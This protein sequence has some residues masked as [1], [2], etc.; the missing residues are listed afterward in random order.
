[1][2]I[3]HTADWHLGR[4]LYHKTRYE[5]FRQFLDWLLEAVQQH[6]IDVLI[7]AGDVFDTTAPSNRA[8]ELYYGFLSLLSKTC[9]RHVV[10]IAG[11]HDS[12]T[13]LE[14]PRKLLKSFD[15][16][17][18]GNVPDPIEEEVILLRDRNGDPE[19]I[20]CAVPY[21]RDRDVRKSE[22]GESL[23]AKEK[24]LREGIESHY[25]KVA[26]AAVRLRDSLPARIPIVAMGHLFTAGGATVEGDGVRS[27]YVGNLAHVES[28]IFPPCL[29]YVALGHLHVPQ[30]VGSS[31]TIR[32]SGSPIP[33]G[34]GEAGQKKSVCIVDWRNGTQT[35]ELLEVPL[36]QRLVQIKGD[37]PEIEAHLDSLI[38]T[39][40][41]MWL[42]VVYQGSEP[43]P[44][45]RERV[46]KRLEGTS[47]E[48]LRNINFQQHAQTL[49]LENPAENLKELDEREVFQR[50]LIRSKVPEEQWNDLKA[51]YQEIM[52][53]Y[54]EE[55]PQAH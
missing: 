31:E 9:C 47:L 23:D 34:F 16:H 35:I 10:I 19:L 6:A 50:C 26:A 32:Y 27:L 30:T 22:A 52:T 5:E 3:L 28:Q 14:A 43:M 55:D 33:M 41:S 45:L 24:K 21:L 49:A 17:V 4:T 2:R 48:S 1:M 46:E 36:F 53:Q 7:V 18:I 39:S 13:F 54:H 51:A 29:D 44:D 25:A 15:V 42:E 40:E 12:P 37:W 8:Q 38:Q 11:N 20:V